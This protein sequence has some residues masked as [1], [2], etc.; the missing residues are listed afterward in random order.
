MMKNPRFEEGKI[1]KDVRNLF[2]LKEKM[3]YI[4]NQNK[5]NLFRREIESKEIKDRI[6]SDINNKTK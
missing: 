5:I 6:L 3:N 4:A 1:I 2:S